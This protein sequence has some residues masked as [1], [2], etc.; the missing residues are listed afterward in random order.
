MEDFGVS[1]ELGFP[2]DVSHGWWL[3]L[4]L[5]LRLRKRDAR[6][7]SRAANRWFLFS[8]CQ[9]HSDDT[10]TSTGFH[11]AQLLYRTDT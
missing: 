4:P 3:P 2:L 7:S 9:L 10:Y 8:I 5:P 1:A 11:K 6:A